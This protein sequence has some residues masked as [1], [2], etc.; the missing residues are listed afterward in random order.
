VVARASLLA[1]A[2]LIV[3]APGVGAAGR[4]DLRQVAPKLV[5]PRSGPTV[6]VIDEVRNVGRRRARATRTR[7]VLSRDRRRSGDDVLLGQRRVPALSRRRSSRRRL[8]LRL[9]ADLAG[10]T[11][12]LLA[13]AD[14]T[15]R[16]RERRE[17]NNCRA[18]RR[19]LR[20]PGPAPPPPGPPQPPPQ[21]SPAAR[22]LPIP[23]FLLEPNRPP[24]A[25]TDPASIDDCGVTV[26]PDNAGAEAFTAMFRQATAGWTGGDGT[27]STRL[28]GGETLWLFGD[29]FLGGVTATGG[30]ERMYPDV[31]NTAVRQGSCVTTRFRGRITDPAPFELG[32][33]NLW[34]WPNQPVVHGDRIRVFW[35]RMQPVADLYA[36]FGV[37]L[38]TYDLGLNRLG[39]NTSIPTRSNQWWGAAVVD[40]PPFTYVFGIQDGDPRSVLLARTPLQNLDGTWEYRTASGWSRNLADAV[41]VLTDAHHVATQLSVLR[42]GAGWALV[43]QDLPGD[44][45]N[46][47]RGSAPWAWGP[48]RTLATIPP[49]PGAMTYNAMVH[50]QFSNGREL[51]ISYNVMALRPELGAADGSLY[52]PRFLRAAL[53]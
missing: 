53:P 31:S 25:T 23:I 9:P 27:F 46:V 34:H 6:R 4:P 29:T 36:A 39:V 19:V 18:A 7:F 5:G 20:V 33:T 17:R 21:P 30:R 32:G 12:R 16:V 45:V 40:D 44:T 43:S 52:R 22:L 28:P 24:P 37:T 49:V 2:V 14:A 11:W 13:C 26:P 10:G 47:W 15:R 1:A 3:A 51:L 48:R 41:P 42:D 50:P 8:T 38:A 35:T